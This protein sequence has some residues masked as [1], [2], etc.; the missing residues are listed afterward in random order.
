MVIPS[1][2]SAVSF[3]SHISTRTSTPSRL[4]EF[5]GPGLAGEFKAGKRGALGSLLS[6]GP[7]FGLSSLSSPCGFCPGSGACLLSTQRLMHLPF[8]FRAS[9]TQQF[10]PTGKYKADGVLETVR[11]SG[12]LSRNLWLCLG[13]VSF[14]I[15]K[16]FLS[17]GWANLP[18]GPGQQNLPPGIGVRAE[19]GAFGMSSGQNWLYGQKSDGR[20]VVLSL[21]R[22]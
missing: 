21:Y 12:K 20:P 22:T 2:P 19:A 1:S 14:H 17:W 18:C 11:L 15:S 5:S 16:S 13:T 4:V 7:P 9:R 8:L 3:P 10:S 6:F